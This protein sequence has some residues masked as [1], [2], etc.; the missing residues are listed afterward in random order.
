[1][2]VV[3]YSFTHKVLRIDVNTV[4]SNKESGDNFDFEGSKSD[5]NFKLSPVPKFKR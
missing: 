2:L 3:L 5:L 4:T 1:M